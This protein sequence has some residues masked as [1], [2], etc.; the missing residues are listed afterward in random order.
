MVVEHPL[1]LRAAVEADSGAQE[2]FRRFLL[3]AL[4]ET[5]GAKP[6]PQLGLGVGSILYDGLSQTQIWFDWF[7][8]TTP[9]TGLFDSI[10][11]DRF[12]L[13]FHF[14][15]LGIT[16]GV[17][18]A[19][20]KYVERLRGFEGEFLS[21]LL[22]SVTGMLLLVSARELIS[23]YVALELTALPAAALAAFRR[24]NFSIEAGIKFI[25]LSAVSSTILL[26][27]IAFI[28]G[29]TGSTNLDVIFQRLS[30]EQIKRIV[31]LQVAQL[32]ARVRE[33]G[34]E[35]E[36]TD[37]ARELL[38]NLG[39]DPTYGARPLKRVI[40]QELQ[41]PLATELLKGEF[42]EGTTIRIDF[43]GQ[44]FTF[45]SIGGGDGAGRRGNKSPGDEIIAAEVV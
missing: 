33:R 31:D 27:G 17:V 9:D 40:Q 42:A 28:Y 21:L 7:G 14:V 44:D 30:K 2:V 4:G 41:N 8:Q 25:L 20:V 6:L 35:V 15:L 38:A 36:L 24:D 39:W 12:A 45:E 32:V 26:Y 10:T 18:M 1:A 16:A 34:V 13:F 29:F 19:S 5:V 3:V 37:G 22:F 23:I 11:G 43:D